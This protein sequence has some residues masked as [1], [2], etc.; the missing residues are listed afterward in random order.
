MTRR[1]RELV[2]VDPLLGFLAGIALFGFVLLIACAV[3]NRI[4]AR[5]VDH[6]FALTE[7]WGGQLHGRGEVLDVEEDETF[8]RGTW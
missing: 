6:S 5:N 3:E 8:A 7:D 4:H 1:D 2:V